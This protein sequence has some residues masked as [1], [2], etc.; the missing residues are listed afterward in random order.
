MPAG[1]IPQAM[2]RQYLVY[3]RQAA[4]EKR[5]LKLPDIYEAFSRASNNY[6]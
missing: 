2:P 4:M 6:H 5:G 3:M 1:D